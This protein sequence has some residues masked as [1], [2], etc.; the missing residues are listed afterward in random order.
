MKTIANYSDEAQNPNK[1]LTED[2]ARKNEGWDFEDEDFIANQFIELWEST[3][4]R[5]AVSLVVLIV[6]FG[7]LILSLI[8]WG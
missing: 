8:M 5:F 4:V 2:A 6:A 1:Y 7:A 3:A